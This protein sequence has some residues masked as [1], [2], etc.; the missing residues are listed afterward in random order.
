MASIISIIII[1]IL[2]AIVFTITYINRVP[3]VCKI[4]P[5]LEKVRR[6]L[7]KLD[8]KLERLQYFQGDESYTEDKEKIFICMKDA[9]GKYY[10]YNTL[11]LVALHEAA[12]ALCSVVDKDHVTPEFNNLHNSLREKASEMGLVDLKKNVPGGYCPKK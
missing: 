12:H 5:I 6:N 3:D 11:F 1:V 7:I 9:D 8:P 10:S 4:N 2:L